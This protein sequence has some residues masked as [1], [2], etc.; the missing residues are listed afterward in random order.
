MNEEMESEQT[1]TDSRLDNLAV[2]ED[3]NVDEAISHDLRKEQ[4]TNA[5]K[6]KMSKD[7]INI[8][9]HETRKRIITT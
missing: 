1:K 7:I 3:A 4:S 5:Y 6:E 8:E 9:S 2:S